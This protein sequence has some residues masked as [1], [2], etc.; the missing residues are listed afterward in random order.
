MRR[1][2]VIRRLVAGA[3]TVLVAVTLNFLLFRAVPGTA[4]SNLSEVPNASP[5]LKEA[6]RREFGLDKPKSEQYVLYLRQLAHGNLGISYE[7]RQPVTAN[8]RKA[9][10]NSLPMVALGI[11]AALVLAGVTAILAAWRRRTAFDYVGTGM[12]IT[13]SSLPTHW[14]ALMLLIGFAGTLPTGGTTDPFLVHATWSERVVDRLSHM[15]LPSLTLALSLYGGLAL[16]FRSTLLETLGEDYILTARAKG[17]SDWSVLRAHALRNALLP[18]TTIIGLYLAFMVTGAILVETVFSWPGVGRAI[19][20]AVLDRDY[21][22]L[23]G[24][25]LLLTLSV[26]V[27]NLAVDLL[28]F[29]LDPRIA[30]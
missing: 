11:A 24:A 3:I 27:T 19:Y 4:I 6:L 15:A 2:F 18:T 14:L 26:V 20:Q 16:I 21:P 30:G 5:E 23:Q 17:L 1:T 10:G 29:K 12:A 22:M 8:L 9:L 7:N 25:F 13:S 28:Y